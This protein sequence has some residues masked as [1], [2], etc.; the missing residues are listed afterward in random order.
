MDFNMG[1]FDIFKK[2]VKQ[3]SR[4][5]EPKRDAVPK[6]ASSGNSITV[7]ISIP[8]QPTQAEMDAMVTPVEMRVKT[9]IVSK[10]GLYPHEIL[11]LDYAHTFYTSGNSFQ[12]FWWYRYGIRDVQSILS[13]LVERGF[14]K[15]GDLKAVL[16]RQTAATLKEVM[17]LHNITTTGKKD[18]LIQRIL[19]KIPESELNKH[20]PKRTYSL[21]ITGQEAL[22]E[23][24]Y[25]PYIHRHPVEDLDI[26]SLNRLVHTK[27]YMPYRDKIWGYLNQRSMKHFS[28]H[29]YGL[30]RN[31]RFSMAQFLKDENKLKDVL[32]MLAEVVFFDLSGAGNNY[33]TRHLDI[34][35]AGF[36][37]YEKSLAKTAPGV[38]GA[39]ADCQEKLRFSDED[40]K[41]VL[42]ERMS[43]LSA[44]LQLFTV[45]EC[46][47][48]ILLERDN[49]AEALTKLYDEA[50]STFMQKYPNIK[51]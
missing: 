44:P 17:K 16:D 20:F 48:I 6:M 13:L 47:Q 38:I 37:P 3:Q 26:W 8:K 5:A 4:A 40:L 43:K 24:A 10:H 7:N 23:E 9:A 15:I 41:S 50:K 31:C 42:L 51:L 19:D 25:V 49:D 27:P 2:T 36:F 21:T 45:E 12:G 18:E 39:I 29:N 32:A 34:Y 22:D 33:D 14:L 35:A 11:V 28:E 1:L 30:Y 46:V